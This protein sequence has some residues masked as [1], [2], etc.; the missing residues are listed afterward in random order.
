MATKQKDGYRILTVE[1][2]EKWTEAVK[3]LAAANE[4]KI[5]PIGTLD[6]YGISWVKVGGESG[7]KARPI[8]PESVIYDRT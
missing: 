6:L 8:R 7:P 3:K 2:P 1:L 5:G 4:Q